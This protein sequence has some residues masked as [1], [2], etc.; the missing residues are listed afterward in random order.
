MMDYFLLT[1]YTDNISFYTEAA[2]CGCNKNPP[3]RPKRPNA[4]PQAGIQK[5]KG[6]C[7]ATFYMCSEWPLKLCDDTQFLLRGR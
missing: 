5:A 1:L 7:S 2:Q 4:T 6:I 3:L